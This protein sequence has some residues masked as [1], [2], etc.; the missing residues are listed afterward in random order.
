[1]VEIAYILREGQDQLVMVMKEEWEEL[2]GV[3]TEAFSLMEA[4]AGLHGDE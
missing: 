4:Q 3:I 1:M 2:K